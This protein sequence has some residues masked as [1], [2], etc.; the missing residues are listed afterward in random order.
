MKR[1]S[2]K[3]EGEFIITDFEPVVRIGTEIENNTSVIRCCPVADVG[4]FGRGKSL[5][6]QEQGQKNRHT[7]K[8]SSHLLCHYRT[9]GLNYQISTATATFKKKGQGSRSKVKGEMFKLKD[10]LVPSVAEPVEAFLVPCILYLVPS[11][12][13][14]FIKIVDKL[15]GKCD[16][17]PTN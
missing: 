13:K 10:Y 14:L 15:S 12:L 3:I 2:G 1:G 8:Q 16:F 11:I 17:H 7:G 9:H 5:S 6:R 4:D